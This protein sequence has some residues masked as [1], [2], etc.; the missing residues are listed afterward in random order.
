MRFDRGLRTKTL[1]AY[2]RWLLT[3]F[4]HKSS[5]ILGV[6]GH[7]ELT[8]HRF[9]L[10]G[11]MLYGTTM[12]DVSDSQTPLNATFRLKVNGEAVV[13]DAVGPAYRFIT[14][15]SSVEWM[16]FRSLHEGAIAALEAAADNAMM[17]I[18]A[19]NALR[20]LFVRAKLL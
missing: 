14:R 18:P 9:P 6:R 15:L 10:R 8:T 7:R 17:S 2:T 13:I 4:Q 11:K 3:Q 19:T 12:T 20:T 5:D 1:T 16:E